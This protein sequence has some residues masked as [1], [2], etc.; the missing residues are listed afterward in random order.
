[1]DLE[2][3]PPALGSSSHTTGGFLHRRALGNILNDAHF[4]KVHSGECFYTSN[5]QVDYK[6]FAY[7]VYKD[8]VQL[9]VIPD[10]L[11]PP[12]TIFH[13]STFPLLESVVVLKKVANQLESVTGG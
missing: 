5:S 6:I 3:S 13:I 1:M 10:P 9:N 11:L 2:G 12:N 7:L 4:P 8:S